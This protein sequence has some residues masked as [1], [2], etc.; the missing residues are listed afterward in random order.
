MKSSSKPRNT[1][2][3]FVE[4]VKRA[5]SKLYPGIGYYDRTVYA[6]VVGTFNSSGRVTAGSKLWSVDLEILGPDL[7]PDRSRAPIKDVPVDPLEVSD[8]GRALFPVLFEGT[9]VRLGWMYANR[10]LPYI[11]SITAEWM[12]LPS[13][14]SGQLSVLVGDALEILA[15]LRDSASGPV[16]MKAQDYAELRRIISSLPGTSL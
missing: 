13:G 10:S 2:D 16:V 7:Q 3:S 11:V 1:F 9:I 5:C 8:D 4:L 15:R 14:S 6:R 12:R